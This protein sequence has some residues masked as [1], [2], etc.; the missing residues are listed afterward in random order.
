MPAKNPTLNDLS[1]TVKLV[2]LL[3]QYMQDNYHGRYYAKAQNLAR[4]LV[5]AY[6][7]ALREVDLLVMPTLPMKATVIPAADASREEYTARALEM[8]PNTCPF[9]VTG[10]PAMNVPCALSSGLPVGMMLIGR[11]GD[12]TTIL[13]AADAFEKQIFSAPVPGQAAAAA[14]S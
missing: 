9:D 3:G 4:N 14:K 8:I 10:H 2:L 11:K 12:E 6:D 13:R 1:E 5:G 7:E